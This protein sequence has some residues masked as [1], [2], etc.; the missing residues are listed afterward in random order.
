MEPESESVS[1]AVSESESES[2]ILNL[3]FEISEPQK[4]RR[5][6]TMVPRKRLT[7]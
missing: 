6:I 1:E 5:S 7:Q 3:K 2:E 4:Y